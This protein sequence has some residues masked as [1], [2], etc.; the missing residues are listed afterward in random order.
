MKSKQVKTKSYPR[1]E[2]VGA[3]V[4]T[5]LAKTLPRYIESSVGL[6]TVS[7]V[8]I[9]NDMRW[10]KVWISILG[11]DDKKVFA[12]I[13][14]NI[15]DIQGEVNQELHMKLLPKLQFVL[16]T[17]PRYAQRIDELIREIHEEDDRTLATPDLHSGKPPS[18][19]Q[20]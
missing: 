3:L 13:K 11:G 19:N 9:S 8:Q 12:T 18:S 1:T 17:T 7:R 16:D 5:V 20:A 15:Y 6:V 2:A 10:A 14:R 4:H